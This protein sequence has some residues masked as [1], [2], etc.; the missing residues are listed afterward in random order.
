LRA[1][2]VA[3]IGGLV[4]GHILWLI[5]ISLAIATTTVNSWVLVIAACVLVASAA[6][7][8]LSR[9]MHQNKSYVWSTFLWCLPIS[10]LVF[11]LV[12]LGVTYV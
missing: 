1:T 6:A 12:V 2:I 11:T 9:R 5:A 4:I 7:F 8:L 10:P 3:G